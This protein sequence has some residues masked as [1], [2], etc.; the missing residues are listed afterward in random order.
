M[1]LAAV[2]KCCNSACGKLS[3]FSTLASD[4]HA[5]AGISSQDPSHLHIVLVYDVS[6]SASI[7]PLG[8][9][10]SLQQRHHCTS[11]HCVAA[12]DQCIASHCIAARVYEGA[13][14]CSVEPQQILQA[15]WGLLGLG[16]DDVR[17]RLLP[18]VVAEQAE[19]FLINGD[20]QSNLYTSSRAMHS[21]IL[22]LLQVQPLS[23]AMPLR[24]ISRW[25][26]AVF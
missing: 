4:V 1:P 3:A 26:T 22:G 13:A 24:A 19:M 18:D 2:G 14:S 21:A 20:M 10:T 16:V 12:S 11:L 25:T 9:H 5:D 7:I 15:D 8:K 17:V 6:G 23:L